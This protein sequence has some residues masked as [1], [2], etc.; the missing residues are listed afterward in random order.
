MGV[1]DL[2]GD[3]HLPF[4]G[5]LGLPLLGAV[6]AFTVRP[7]I[8]FEWPGGPSVAADTTRVTARQTRGD[9]LIETPRYR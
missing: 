6:L 9:R 2:T 3:W 4:Q 8:A 7:D 1:S 5:S